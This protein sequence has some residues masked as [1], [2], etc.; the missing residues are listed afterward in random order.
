MNAHVSGLWV[1]DSGRTNKKR[2]CVRE[3]E[4]ERGTKIRKLT[5]KSPE[6][7]VV[8]FNFRAPDVWGSIQHSR[9]IMSV[10]ILDQLSWNGE[11]IK[12]ENFFMKDKK[13]KKER[14]KTRI[15][16]TLGFRIRVRGQCPVTWWLPVRYVITRCVEC[17]PALAFHKNRS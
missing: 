13:R 4:R 9:P 15:W 12:W 14:K 11:S 7:T 5:H 3:R 16:R 1:M 8:L 2:T 6:W 10:I 17:A